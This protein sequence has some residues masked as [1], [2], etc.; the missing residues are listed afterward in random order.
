MAVNDRKLGHK[1]LTLVLIQDHIL[2]SSS[3]NKQVNINLFLILISECDFVIISNT[4]I[5]L[6]LLMFIAFFVVM[7]F[8][9]NGVIE[10]KAIDVSVYTGCYDLGV[11]V[12]YGYVLDVV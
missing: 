10:R 1:I 12:G 8:I 11:I 4:R 9:M 6:R 5:C 2:L 7:L 3:P